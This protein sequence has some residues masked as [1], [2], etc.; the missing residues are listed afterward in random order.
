M[1][2]RNGLIAVVFLFCFKSSLLAQPAWEVPTG[3][4]FCGIKI[5]SVN[6]CGILVPPV[7]PIDT[8]AGSG[9]CEASIITRA[10]GLTLAYS[11]YCLDRCV[12]LDSL[13]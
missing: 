13:G 1:I 8:C 7:E 4:A 2:M 6:R 12:L 10:G 11:M 3:G 9:K 5:N